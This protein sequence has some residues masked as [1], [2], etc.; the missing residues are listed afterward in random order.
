MRS[1]H[2]VAALVVLTSPGPVAL[3]QTQT[4]IPPSP[5]AQG[6]PTISKTEFFKALQFYDS[7]QADNS[8]RMGSN[9][10]ASKSIMRTTGN[11]PNVAQN[12]REMHYEWLYARWDHG[13]HKPVPLMGDLYSGRSNRIEDIVPVQDHCVQVVSD[14]DKED[15]T[16]PQ[17]IPVSQVQDFMDQWAF[18]TVACVNKRLSEMRGEKDLIAILCFQDNKHCFGPKEYPDEKPN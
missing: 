6:E 5:P 7:N 12:A 14:M 16:I 9:N 1:Y 13:A 15:Q 2:L 8:T 18:M 11:T 3:A 10:M 17:R 4:P